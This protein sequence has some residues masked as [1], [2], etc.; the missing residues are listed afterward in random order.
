MTRISIFCVLCAGILLWVPSASGKDK[1]EKRLKSPKAA[2]ETGPICVPDGVLETSR[3]HESNKEPLFRANLRF[4]SS[5]RAEIQDYAEHY[6]NRGSGKPRRLPPGLEKKVGRGGALP[7]GW[8][9]KCI[10]GEIMPAEVYERCRPLPPD[11]V[12]RLPPAPEPT[13]TVAI[14]GKVVRLLQATLEILDV[15]DINVKL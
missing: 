10:V 9:K 3:I 15:F 12:L 6:G 7:P 11:L 8:Q 14:G 5:E 4:S 13:V 2:A 1:H